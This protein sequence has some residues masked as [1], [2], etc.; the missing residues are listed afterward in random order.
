VKQGTSRLS[1]GFTPQGWSV[2]PPPDAVGSVILTFTDTAQEP[3]SG[4]YA[5]SFHHENQVEH[6]QVRKRTDG[7]IKASP[8]EGPP[9]PGKNPRQQRVWYT[10]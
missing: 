8:T 5:G 6:A 9:N 4:P 10:H 2:T 3:G 7:P 1:P